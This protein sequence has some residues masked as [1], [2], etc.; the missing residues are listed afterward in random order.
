MLGYQDGKGFDMRVLVD[1]DGCELDLIVD[2]DTDF[3]GRFKG[4]CNDTG[5]W[6]MVNGWLADEIT[7]V[8]E[9]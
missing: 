4:K 2:S 7:V 3:D 5:E 1:I 9:A 6:L 8:S